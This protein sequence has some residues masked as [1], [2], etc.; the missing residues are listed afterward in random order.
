MSYAQNNFIT[1]A[2]IACSTSRRHPS[3]PIR[4]TFLGRNARWLHCIW[5]SACAT[6]VYNLYVMVSKHAIV[7]NLLQQRAARPRLVSLAG[8]GD[9]IAADLLSSAI[10]LPGLRA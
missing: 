8:A 5:A 1:S 7:H 4:P 10:G 6:R 3:C 9:D 2:T